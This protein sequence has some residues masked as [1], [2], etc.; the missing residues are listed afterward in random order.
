M[1]RRYL[2]DAKAFF[3]FFQAE[4]GIRGVAVTGVQTCA[5][6]ISAAAH[7]R[8]DQ[9]LKMWCEG[10]VFY[11]LFQRRGGGFNLVPVT[12]AR[13]GHPG[14]RWRG[15]LCKPDMILRTSILLYFFF[16]VRLAGLA[17]TPAIGYW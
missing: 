5:L 10:P 1:Y 2:R 15:L 14:R 6:P 7:W 13:A 16:L 12:L 8:K 17:Q 9:T 4:G 11:R 3:F